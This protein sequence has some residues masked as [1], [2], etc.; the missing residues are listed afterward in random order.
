MRKLAIL[1][2]LLML[3]TLPCR[4]TDCDHQYVEQR[5]EPTCDTPG[6]T[7]ME[8]ILCGD[9]CDFRS[10]DAPGH[11]F[12]E[13][14]LLEE[15][16]CQKEGLEARDCVRCGFQ[17]QRA[18]EHIGHAYVVEVTAP[19]C[20]ARGYTTHYCPNCGDRFRTDYT[21]PLGH[22]YDAGVIT[23]EPSLTAM[24]RTRFTCLGCGDTYLEMIPILTNPFEDLDD[25]AFYFIPVLWAVGRGITTGMD[26]TH[27]CPTEPC[28]RAQVAAFLWRMAGK[29][30][31][32][33]T[34]DPFVDVVAGSFY[35]QAVLWAWEQGI[36]NGMDATH[37]CP[38][39]T[40]TRAQVVTFLYRCNGCPETGVHSVFPDVQEGSYFCDAVH[41]AAQRGITVGM[42]GGKFC[43]EVLCNRAQ[44]LTFLYRDRLQP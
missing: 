7:W 30:E 23:K 16:T 43:P 12:A 28:N 10:L 40:C 27:F 14:Y 37:F 6:M 13:W 8:C 1:L 44:I 19:T 24:G 42:D 21:D 29:P 36:T 15:P 34:E 26:E 3:L 11:E 25:Q 38:L 32:K 17:E 35:E 41:W 31:P 4:A 9:T 20:T 22:R 5:Q 18:V 2:T 39:E 33:T